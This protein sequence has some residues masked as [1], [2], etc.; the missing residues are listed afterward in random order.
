MSETMQVTSASSLTQQT[1]ATPTLRSPL[2]D[3]P[4]YRG[5]QAWRDPWAPPELSATQAL[6]VPQAPLGPQPQDDKKSVPDWTNTS[7]ID[8]I[9]SYDYRMF[10]LIQK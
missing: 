2:W 1:S 4:G 9:I 3:P 5:R 10:P 7:V 8:L 6:P